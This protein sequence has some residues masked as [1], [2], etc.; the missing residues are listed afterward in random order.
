MR[1][2]VRGGRVDRK[3]ERLK[4]GCRRQRENLRNRESVMRDKER[5]R[6]SVCEIEI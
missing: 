1:K 3:E 5:E 4:R 6:E 2:R